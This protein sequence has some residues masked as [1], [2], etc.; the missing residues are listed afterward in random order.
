M[1]RFVVVFFLNGVGHQLVDDTAARV[2]VRLM[3]VDI[4]R[5]NLYSIHLDVLIC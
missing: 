1:Q 4:G 2:Y 5:R 3:S